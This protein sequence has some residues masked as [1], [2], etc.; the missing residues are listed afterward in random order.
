MSD[1]PIS[2]P[3]VMTE[4]QIQ[5]VIEAIKNRGGNITYQD[6]RLTNIY[7]VASTIIGL[8]IVGSIS[9][10]IGSINELNRNVSILI[11]QHENDTRRIDD[12]ADRVK[13]LEARHDA[14]N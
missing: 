3:A 2:R 10:G 1:S 7:N 4:E 12:I 5:K 9:W 8:L 6:S 14:R 13:T 11:T